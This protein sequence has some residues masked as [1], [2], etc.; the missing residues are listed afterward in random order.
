MS[1]KRVCQCVAKCHQQLKETQISSRIKSG[2]SAILP[3]HAG[4]HSLKGKASGFIIPRRM[5]RVTLAK[6]RKSFDWSLSNSQRDATK[7]Y[8]SNYLLLPTGFQKGF[9]KKGMLVCL[10]SAWI[11]S[12]S[13]TSRCGSR[14]SNRGGGENGLR[15]GTHGILDDRIVVE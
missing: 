9:K 8:H 5:D 3:Y 15:Q 1:S 11:Y 7:N 6:E 13:Q 12:T 4:P 14:Q 2:F 10:R